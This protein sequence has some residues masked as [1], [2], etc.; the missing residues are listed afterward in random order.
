MRTPISIA[1]TP[2]T[3]RTGRRAGH[4]DWR[5]PSEDGRNSPFTGARELESILL[6]PSPPSP[7]GTVPCIDPIFGPTVAFYYWSATTDPTFPGFARSGRHELERHGR[8]SGQMEWDRGP[9]LQGQRPLR[10]GS[11]CRLV[12]DSSISGVARRRLRRRSCTGG[13]KAVASEPAWKRRR[14]PA[15][16]TGKAARERQAIEPAHVPASARTR[17]LRRAT[18]LVPRRVS[19]CQLR[20]ATRRGPG[21]RSGHRARR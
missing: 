3:R 4:C 20:Q 15:I 16:S 21:S 8:Q 14:R 2:A 11:P 19:G 5:L 6:A 18:G 12:S 10:S 7:C 17:A 1:T 9:R 13:S